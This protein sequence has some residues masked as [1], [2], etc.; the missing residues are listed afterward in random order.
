[1]KLYAMLSS[2]GTACAETVLTAKEYKQVHIRERVEKYCCT[3]APDAPV[4]GSWTDVSDNEACQYWME[5]SAQR[6]Q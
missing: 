4:K 2:Q 6:V 3:G 1:M 5:E